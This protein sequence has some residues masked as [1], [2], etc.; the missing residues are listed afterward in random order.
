MPTG[1]DG[2]LRDSREAEGATT[3][4]GCDG[5][6]YLVYSDTIVHGDTDSDQEANLSR[7]SERV[8]AHHSAGLTSRA[9]GPSHEEVDGAPP[10]RRRFE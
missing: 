1:T 4:T 10:P 6:A 9:M 3:D 7:R 5:K 2:T 8:E